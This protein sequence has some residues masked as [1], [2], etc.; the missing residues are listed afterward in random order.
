M[1]S[2]GTNSYHQLGQ[3]PTPDHCLVPK[4]INCKTVKGRNI[5]GICAGRFHSVLHT[6]TAAFTCGLNAGQLGKGMKSLN[7]FKQFYMILE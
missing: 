7:F 3:H 6:S 4:P 5:I 2:C 1:Y